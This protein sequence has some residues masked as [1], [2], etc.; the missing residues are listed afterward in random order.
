[1]ALFVNENDGDAHVQHFGLVMLINFINVSTECIHGSC[2]L[3]IQ[4]S[5]FRVIA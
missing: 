1:M 4:L 2:A 3:R 5:E